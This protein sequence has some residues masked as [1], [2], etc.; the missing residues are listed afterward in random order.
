MN[1]NKQFVFRLVWVALVSLTAG[2]GSCVKTVA[3]PGAASLTL[4]NAFVASTPVYTNF[5]D[6]KP[7]TYWYT[8][9]MLNYGLFQS[10]DEMPFYSGTQKVS[11]F[12]YGDTSA[13]STPIINV[14]VDLPVGSYNTLFGIG[15][16]DNPDTLFI[17]DH[18]PYYGMD[19]VAGIRFI[20]VSPGSAPISVNIMGQPNGSVVSS[21]PYKGVTDFIRF[22]ATSDVFDLV[23]EFR[24]AG[25]GN[26]LASRRARA[27]GQPGETYSPNTWQ[28]KNNSMVLIGL[29]NASSYDSAQRVYIMNNY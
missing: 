26:L 15:T 7:L 24:D 6:G 20:N 2:F 27:V 21:L 11:F 18:I 28:F 9:Y 22:P 4:V 5:A 19:S 8:A 25:S 16:V 3:H 23:F 13:H 14:A 12:R 10:M 29:P 1:F 17:R